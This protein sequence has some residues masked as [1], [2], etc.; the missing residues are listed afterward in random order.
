[1]R[2]LT[3][4]E[5][6]GLAAALIIACTFFY[7]KYM[8]DPQTRV[9]KDTLAKRNKIVGELNQVNEVPPLFQLEKIIEKDKTILEDLRKESGNLSVKTG[10]P[11]EITNLL[12]RINRVIE[13][14]RMTVLAIT[15]GESFQGNFFRWNPYEM[16]L[17]G[18]F[19]DFMAFLNDI[20]ELDDAVEILNISVE[21][22]KETRDRLHIKFTLRI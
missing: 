1:M 6:F 13:S 12:A 18:A 16:E 2:T 10:R 9:L 5:K 14:S 4:L 22:S 7:M 17:K 20:K 19:T 11:D 8:Y 15:P 21:N 3:N